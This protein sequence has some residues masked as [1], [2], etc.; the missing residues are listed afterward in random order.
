[1]IRN[2][3][4]KVAHKPLSFSLIRVYLLLGYSML[5]FSKA[6]Y[7]DGA[8]DGLGPLSAVFSAMDVSFHGRCG[9]VK[10]DVNIPCFGEPSGCQTSVLVQDDTN[11]PWQSK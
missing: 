5:D 9:S 6:R 7:L 3:F 2:R 10:C 1:M 4:A 11:R 8:P